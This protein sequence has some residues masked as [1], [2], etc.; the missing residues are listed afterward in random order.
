M[1]V[2]GINSQN[3][4]LK[5][6][7]NSEINLE[8]RYCALAGSKLGRMVRIDGQFDDWPDMSSAVAGD[9]LCIRSDGIND[10]QFKT[11][12]RRAH[13][14][15]QVQIGY[16]DQNLYLAF[17]CLEP[18]EQ[19][20]NKP[21]NTVDSSSGLPWGEDLVA[22]VLDPD[23]TGSLNPLDA[24]QVIVKANGN[25][26]TFRGTLEANSMNASQS[27]P[28]HVRAAVAVFPDRWQ[29]EVCV[30]LSDVN[31]MSKLN[32]WWGIDFARM[33][34]AISEFS[35]W[36]GTT[37]QYACPVSMGNIFLTQ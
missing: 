32:R 37:N 12:D 30:P 19:R 36:S 15:T 16:D 29:A 20:F 22:V 18:Q 35:T 10:Q 9:F 27:W 11:V 25:V 23:N 3:V 8:C 33:S 21:T 2:F 4:R 13:W 1:G 17:T 5:L 28:N 31:A 26:L 34:S 7:D 14:P 24:Y 6:K